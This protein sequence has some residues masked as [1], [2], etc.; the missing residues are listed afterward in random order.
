MRARGG[1]DWPELPAAARPRWPAWYGFAAMG[2]GTVVVSV[3]GIPLVP[4]VLFSVV[5][6]APGAVALLV[7]VLVQDVV[8][9]ATAVGFAWLRGRPRGWHFGL[10]RTPAK[11]TLLLTAAVAAAVLGFEIAFFELV[12]VDESKVD[13]LGGGGGLVAAVAISLAAIVVAPVTEE[14]FFRA[15]LYR[16]LRNRMRVALACAVN[17]LVFA[18]VHVQYLAVPV[19]YVTIAVFAVAACLLYEAT[20]SVL[21]CIAIHALF[22][23]FALA[24][25]AAGYGA[26]V[27]VGA[28]VIL[29]CAVASRR[30]APAPSPFPA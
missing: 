30:L 16:A 25:T 11:R 24:G 2:A 7:L 19:V 22:N 21:P 29:C 3:A 13:E 8:Y 6:G 1:L 20:G 14:L 12:P 5:D 17:A 26:P 23:T 4:L 15:F 9:V 18:L 10:R 27:L 28:V